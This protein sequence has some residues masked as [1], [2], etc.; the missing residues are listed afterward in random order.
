MILHIVVE[1][2]ATREEA[3]AAEAEAIRSEYPRFN[4]AQNG[5]RPPLQELTA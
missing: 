3:L 2:F 4:R 1:P 5:R